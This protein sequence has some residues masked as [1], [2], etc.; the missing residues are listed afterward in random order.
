MRRLLIVFFLLSSPAYAQSDLAREMATLRQLVENQNR[1]IAEQSAQL[2]QLTDR[3]TE[4]ERHSATSE[5]DATGLVA[6]EN[7][8][9]PPQQSATIGERTEPLDTG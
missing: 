3:V 2:G 8:P 1:L 7:E 4:L 6:I 9:L 5:A